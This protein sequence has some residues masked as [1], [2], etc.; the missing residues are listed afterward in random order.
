[1]RKKSALIW[2]LAALLAAAILAG[3]LLHGRRPLKDLRAGDVTEIRAGL[4][5]PDTE[6]ILTREEIEKLVPLLNEV[7]IY[8]EDDSFREYDGQ[9]VIFTVTKKDGTKTTLQAYNPFFIIDGTGY[10]TKYAPCEALNRFGN[11]LTRK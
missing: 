7:V 8:R 10:R 5:P 6:V 2:G 11:G 4:Y 1:M 3:G 9:A